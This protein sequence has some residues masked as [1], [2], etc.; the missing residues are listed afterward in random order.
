[1]NVTNSTES[2]LIDSNTSSLSP[3]VSFLLF[4]AL[5]LVAGGLLIA[6]IA[7]AMYKCRSRA[8]EGKTPK[9]SSNGKLVR[10]NGGI[11]L[12]ERHAEEGRMGQLGDGEGEL[13][14][15]R[16]AVEARADER[17]TQPHSTRSWQTSS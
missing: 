16:R 1:M 4:V 15:V 3:A 6:F 7:W 9:P 5:P 2:S 10:R 17:A 14:R 13:K 12:Q 11:V 8:K